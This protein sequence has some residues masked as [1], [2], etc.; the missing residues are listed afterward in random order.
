[1]AVT[2]FRGGWLEF[3]VRYPK[4]N[5]TYKWIKVDDS[6]AVQSFN[7]WENVSNLL[8]YHDTR[9]KEVKVGI[10]DLKLDTT[11][12]Y[13]IKFYQAKGREGDETDVEVKIGKIILLLSIFYSII[14]QSRCCYISAEGRPGGRFSI[15][16]S[17]FI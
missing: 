9:N 10:K 12:T 2:G 1:M 11:K 8:L 5:R 13:E 3:S 14:K 15:G 17:V 7:S 16:V 6:R 4:K